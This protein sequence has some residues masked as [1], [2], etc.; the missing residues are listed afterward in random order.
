MAKQQ[1]LADTLQKLIQS[2][3]YFNNGTINF[4][5]IAEELREFYSRVISTVVL[6]N[7]AGVHKPTLE[8]PI[9]P[10]AIPLATI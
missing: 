1:Y 9:Y 10:L 2:G 6:S 4:D 5:G 7:S 8:S 3:K